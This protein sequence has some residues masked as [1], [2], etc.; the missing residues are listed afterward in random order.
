MLSFWDHLLLIT[1]TNDNIKRFLRCS[2][3]YNGPLQKAVDIFDR[4][5][6]KRLQQVHKK[7]ISS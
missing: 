7:I 6:I 5:H 3:M 4:D 1:L 2:L